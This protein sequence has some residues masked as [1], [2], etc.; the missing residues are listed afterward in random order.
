MPLKT[1]K[2]VDWPQDRPTIVD[3][4]A[5]ADQYTNFEDN[6]ATTKD[7]RRV[8]VTRDLTVE[9]IYHMYYW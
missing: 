6:I 7:G 8:L 2:T 5:S 3:W 9:N 4:V 1:I